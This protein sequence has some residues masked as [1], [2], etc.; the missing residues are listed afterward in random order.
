MAIPQENTSLIFNGLQSDIETNAVK[1]SIN[2]IVWF[3]MAV[4]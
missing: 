1:R 2:I 4:L 3:L